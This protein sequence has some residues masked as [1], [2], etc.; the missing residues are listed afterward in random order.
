MD[1]TLVI[2]DLGTIPWAAVHTFPGCVC[3]AYKWVHS[4]TYLQFHIMSS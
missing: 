2:N 1:E 3:G 4:T